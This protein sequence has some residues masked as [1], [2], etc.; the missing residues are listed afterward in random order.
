MDKQQIVILLIIL[1]TAGIATLIAYCNGRFDGQRRG[2]LKAAISASKVQAL[3]QQLAQEKAQHG[4]TRQLH[5]AE[6]KSAE[7]WRGKRNDLQK[8]HQQLSEEHAIWRG[9]ALEAE[10]QADEMEEA[11]SSLRIQIAALGDEK[12]LAAASLDET[13]AQ[14]AEAE[15]RSIH[16]NDLQL[17]RYA[18]R[19]LQ[20]EA[21]R[22]RKT[23]SQKLNH[24]DLAGS[25]L[26]G[27]IQRVQGTALNELLKAA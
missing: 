16:D 17:L 3:Q 2:A 25:Q 23:G 19:Q 26:Q 11:I 12:L 24:A 4:S 1:A 5:Q 8:I 14:L 6:L 22:F 13:A 27:L 18:L 7:F 15:S 21:A 10:A 20:Q 9:R